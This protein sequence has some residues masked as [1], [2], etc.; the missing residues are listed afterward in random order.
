MTPESPSSQESDLVRR[1]RLQKSRELDL[2]PWIKNADSS[3]CHLYWMSFRMP[4]AFPANRQWVLRF[5]QALTD[6]LAAA[7]E[8]YFFLQMKVIQDYLSEPFFARAREFAPLL[9]L[10]RKPGAALPKLPDAQYIKDLQDGKI[11]Y[12]HKAIQ[13]D[14]A[15]HFLFQDLTACLNE[16]F[17]VGGSMIAFLPTDTR[18]KPPPPRIPLGVSNDPA[19]APLLKFA[20]VSETMGAA[21]RMQSPVFPRSRA[22]F[23]R[24]LEDQVQARGLMFIMPLLSASSFAEASPAD[25]TEWFTFFD[26]V[27]TESPDDKGLVLASKDDLNQTIDE[28]VQ[29]LRQEDLEY[30]D[31]R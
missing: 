15:Y 6:R 4:N 22:I 24:G 18:E 9:G 11:K 19:F 20:K 28:I 1:V 17:G 5:V 13:P 21:H 10:T 30:V 27:L 23:G 25:V 8:P 12:D 26:V 31:Y 2:G 16:F 3:S 14:Y 29:M 7:A